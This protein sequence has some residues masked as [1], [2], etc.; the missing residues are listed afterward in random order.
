MVFAQRQSSCLIFGLASALDHFG[1]V[2]LLEGLHVLAAL[3]KHWGGL[4]VVVWDGGEHLV[5]F[6]GD[7]LL[8][9]LVD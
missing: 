5:E 1:P 4:E 9:Q 2:L 3:I 6:V 7:G 8:L